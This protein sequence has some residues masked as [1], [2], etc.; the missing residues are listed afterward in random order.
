M[1]NR[2]VSMKNGMGVVFT[3]PLTWK[4]RNGWVYNKTAWSHTP[5]VRMVP[6]LGTLVHSPNNSQLGKGFGH[7]RGHPSARIFEV[8]GKLTNP[9]LILQ[10]QLRMGGN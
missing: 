10:R 9:F 6:V 4:L 8:N 3:V 5:I 1:G 2:Q 7:P